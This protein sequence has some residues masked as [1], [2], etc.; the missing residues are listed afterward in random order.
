MDVTMRDS[1]VV[2]SKTYVELF[3]TKYVRL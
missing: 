2:D 1:N 3:C